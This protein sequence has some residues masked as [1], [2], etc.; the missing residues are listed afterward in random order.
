MTDIAITDSEVT[1]AVQRIL[2][3]VLGIEDA[4]LTQSF[5]HLG[6]DSL[7]ALKAA[8]RIAF[9]FNAAA[10]MDGTILE[11]LLDGTTGEALARIVLDSLEQ[12]V[13]GEFE[14]APSTELS[15]GE[16]R[17]WTAHQYQRERSTYH[18]VGGF[19]VTGMLDLAAL[20]RAVRALVDRHPALRTRYA[21]DHPAVDRDGPAGSSVDVVHHREVVPW[22]EAEAAAE[23]GIQEP[24]DLTSGRLLRVRT[25]RTGE[26]EWLLQVILHHIAIDGWSMDI[27]YRE[28]AALYAG[29]HPGPGESVDYR[30]FAQWQRSST[31]ME[32]EAEAWAAR[33]LPLPDRIELGNGRRRRPTR[34]LEGQVLYTDLPPEIGDKLATLAEES[35]TS[36]FVVLLALLHVCLARRT[37]QWDA[38]IGTVVAGRSRPQDHAT[39][40]YFTNTVPVRATA[41]PDATFGELIESLREEWRYVFTH[42]EVPLEE[43]AVR[44]RRAPDPARTPLVDVVM[45]LQNNDDVPLMLAD[46][47]AEPLWMH[48]GTAKFDLMLEAIRVSGILHLSWEYAT[49]V[50]TAEE[51]TELGAAFERLASA[52]PEDGNITLRELLRPTRAELAR[53]DSIDVA[54]SP[55][56]DICGLFETIVARQADDIALY[57]TTSDVTFREL[58]ELRDR[59]AGCLVESGVTPGDVVAVDVPDSALSMAAML[60]T[61]SVGAVVVMIDAGWSG[62]QRDR[63]MS[64][65]RP[66]VLIGGRETNPQGPVVISAGDV[67]VASPCTVAPVRRR[68]DDP[69]WLIADLGAAGK[70]EVVAGSHRGLLDRCTWTWNTFPYEA[71]DVAVVHGLPSPVDA[72]AETLA[73][74]LAGVPLAVLPETAA[75][76]ARTT[77]EWVRRYGG[78]RL[79]VT[80]SLMWTM[81]HSLP[82]VSVALATLRVCAFTGEELDADLLGRVREALPGCRLVNLYGRSE[83]TGYVA[84]SEVTSLPVG[85]DVPL[86][87]PI[88]NT[89]VFVVDEWGETVPPGVV[90]EL[91]VAGA[92]AGM[93]Y[94]SDG[95]VE[96]TGVFRTGVPSDP[97]M[98]CCYTGDL[99]YLDTE[100][101]LIFAGRGDREVRVRG[102]RVE[103]AHVEST[104][105]A[106][107]G[108][109]GAVAWAEHTLSG[110]CILAAVVPRSGAALL[111]DEV[112]LTLQYR[113]PS[114]MVPARVNVIDTLPLTAHG[115]LDRDAIAASIT[116]Q[117]DASLTGS[118]ELSAAEQRIRTIWSQALQG[119]SPGADDNFFALGGDSLA[120]TAMLTAVQ[121]E[122]GIELGVVRFLM[123][124]TIRGI[125]DQLVERGAVA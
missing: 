11:A 87:R 7:R 81:L 13:A 69:T 74:L 31:G 70:P 45:V 66:T 53:I 120:V 78:T 80:P 44:T 108:V 56:A 60:A 33:L 17:L 10:A 42:Q 75:S 62:W 12:E 34:S 23:R 117:R 89:R 14:D 19:R 110:D 63:L 39:V 1:E 4:D 116:T 21:P 103:L 24:F 101:Q 82:E 36:L 113:L 98:P 102:F 16:E 30:D 57:G 97:D 77:A 8:G 118:G 93:G 115:K 43:L 99:G 58:G 40:G 123:Q 72:I 119:E 3:E 90:G 2:S 124:P 71:G 121:R 84:Y 86:G 15:F 109:S 52:L 37:R 61:W 22:S 35:R 50:L 27:I 85:A 64:A 47:V 88:D 55:D 54:G 25:W 106:I 41:S 83:T 104:L 9:E 95:N 18:S 125:V 76:D 29:D 20:D 105:R 5:H 107:D 51:V 38:L 48:T 26:R 96:R 111:G 114:Y 28:L 92:S 59:V 122:F 6:G 100:G 46:C 91:V 73:P 112:R 32:A 65:C 49:E 94:L 79:L 68:P 67:A